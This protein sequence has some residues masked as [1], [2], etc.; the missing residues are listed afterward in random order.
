MHRSLVGA[1]PQVPATRKCEE[2]MIEKIRAI[3][4]IY[5]C[6]SVVALPLVDGVAAVRVAAVVRGRGGRV[7]LVGDGGVGV[8]GLVDGLVD[9]LDVVIVVLGGGLG[10][11]GGGLS[12]LGGT[13]RLVLG[14]GGLLGSRV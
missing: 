7:G 8:D 13:G 4:A 14:D 1:L 9:D 3:V 10:H 12:V 5:G 2:K 11:H 6:F